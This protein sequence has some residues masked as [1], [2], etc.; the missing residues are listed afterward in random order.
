MEKVLVKIFLKMAKAT[1]PADFAALFFGGVVANVV[2]NLPDDYWQELVR[3]SS[4]PCA[5]AGCDCQKMN[6]QILAVMDALRA[7]HKRFKPPLP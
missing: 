7:D 2:G 4:K 6:V 1:P 3:E 5:R